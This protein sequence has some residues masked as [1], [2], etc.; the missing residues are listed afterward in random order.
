MAKTKIEKT[1]LELLTVAFQEDV[2]DKELQHRY[3]RFVKNLAH[4]KE[5]YNKLVPEI[6][7]AINRKNRLHSVIFNTVLE[8]IMP[9]ET[10]YAYKETSKELDELTEE[11]SHHQNGM[12]ENERLIKKYEELS[13]NKLFYWWKSFRAIDPK[14]TAPWMEWKR[15][16]EKMII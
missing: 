11:I 6:N 1:P 15:P 9:A 10:I 4:A 13:H 12:E 2:N 5:Q 16:Y 14:G 7:E 3:D 8:G